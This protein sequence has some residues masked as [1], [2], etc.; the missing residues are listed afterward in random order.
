MQTL[1]RIETERW[2]MHMTKRAICE[3][4]GITDK[5]YRSY[6]SG[7]TPV[8]SDVLITLRSLTGKTVDWLLGFGEEATQ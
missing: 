7:A 5:T 2:R 4:L 8:P 6:I 3:A 1:D